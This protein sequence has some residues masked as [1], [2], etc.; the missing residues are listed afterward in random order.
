MPK[1][2]VANGM[3]FSFAE[4]FLCFLNDF[5]VSFLSC[6]LVYKCT[7]CYALPFFF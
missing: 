3:F 2:L 7:L 1:I 5:F 4:M 6:F